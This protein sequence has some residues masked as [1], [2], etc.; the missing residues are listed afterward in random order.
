MLAILSPHQAP[1]DYIRSPPSSCQGIFLPWQPL[2]PLKLLP[3]VGLPQ[4]QGLLCPL[5][6]PLLPPESRR[7]F[8]SRERLRI[9]QRLY[10]KG[11]CIPLS[12]V[13]SS[14]FPFSSQELELFFWFY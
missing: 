8:R 14:L 13:L 4:P 9:C 10:G 5:L 1:A 7:L 3:P 12:D 2:L 6:L 11:N